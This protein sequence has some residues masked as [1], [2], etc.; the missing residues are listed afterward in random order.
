MKPEEILRELVRLKDLHD[1]IE[2]IAFETMD[3]YRAAVTEYNQK[4]PA[5]WAAARKSLGDQK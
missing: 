1:R 2:C 4:K 3:E 5:A